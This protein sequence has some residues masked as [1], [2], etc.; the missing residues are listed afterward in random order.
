MRPARSTKILLESLSEGASSIPVLFETIMAAGYGASLRRLE[1]VHRRL[2]GKNTLHTL[3]REEERRAIRRYYSVLQSLRRDGLIK[4]KV[5]PGKAKIIEITR[6]GKEK[7]KKILKIQSTALPSVD[8]ESKESP[9]H[10]VVSFD[11][12][13][14]IR[15][16]RDWLRAVLKNLG[17]KKVHQSFWIGKVKMPT[18]FLKDLRDLRLI[19]HIEILEVSK[20]GTLERIA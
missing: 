18:V 1:Y 4:E 12:P 2:E 8:Y 15:R 17:M 13:E 10:T 20:Y 6:K 14:K 11:I 9:T 7:L 16:K 3:G 5:S 19:E